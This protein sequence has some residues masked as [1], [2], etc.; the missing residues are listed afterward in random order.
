MKDNW[1]IVNVETKAREL[2][3]KILLSGFLVNKGFKV[4]LINLRKPKEYFQLPKGI[5]LDRNLFPIRKKVYSLMEDLGNFIVCL[6]EEGLIFFDNSKYLRRI[7]RENLEKT[8]LFLSW[9]NY[10][11]DLMKKTFPEFADKFI[12]S[13]NPRMD[14][15]RNSIRTF[16][17]N[18]VI[19]LKKK[20]G[21]YILFVSNFGKA[22]FFNSEKGADAQNDIVKRLK[23]LG[24]IRN[25]QDED[26][27]NRFL[28]YSRKIFNEFQKLI[29]ALAK[30]FQTL[31]FIV[32]PHPSENFETWK[33]LEKNN[34][35]I[36]VI[37]E[38]TLQPWI[39][40]SLATLQNSCTSSIESYLLNIPSVGFRPYKSEEF[41]P[42]LPNELSIQHDDIESVR[43]FVYN[44]QKKEYDIEKKDHILD[45]FLCNYNE[46]STLSSEF[47]AN[48]L[49]EKF[50][51]KNLPKKKISKIV[52]LYKISGVKGNIK[53]ILYK[54]LK[55]SPKFL[56]TFS[57][58]LY[59]KLNPSKKT[60]EGI[61]GGMWNVFY[62][63]QKF[64]GF[65][66]QEIAEK[67]NRFSQ[68]IGFFSKIKVEKRT[69][70][71]YILSQNP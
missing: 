42:F 48:I 51:N 38:G 37:Y 10:Q 20:Y 67:L 19:K 41:D 26:F 3:A 55:I 64:P 8:D 2:N 12:I 40:G 35:N 60:E 44:I 33:K 25:E 39:M 7:L 70:S 36:I 1:V 50:Y 49:Y 58:W 34:K 18:D 46:E 22:N 66:E 69:N 29:V 53:T 54:I 45:D 17:H 14:L 15:Y 62:Q 52:I 43:K 31:N 16:F 59:F 61:Q 11:H 23:S 56:Q 27:Y 32:R 4:L 71:S 6:D 63:N 30:E 24:T 13:G 57:I 9:G 21:N 5:I 47:I 65:D 28:V 68:N